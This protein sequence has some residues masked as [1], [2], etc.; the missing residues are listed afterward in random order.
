V[1]ESAAPLSH[2]EAIAALTGCAATVT[3][4]SYQEVIEGY[5]KLR[6]WPDPA[7][8]A[9]PAAEIARLKRLHISFDGPYAPGISRQWLARQLLDSK[10]SDEE[11]FGVVAFHPTITDHRLAQDL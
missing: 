7:K 5:F 3:V 1:T 9:E 8:F 2:D 11:A 4:L 6:G 10:L